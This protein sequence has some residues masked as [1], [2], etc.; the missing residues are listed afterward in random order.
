MERV[1]SPIME[2]LEK[3]EETEY[4]RNSIARGKKPGRLSQRIDYENGHKDN[5]W[6]GKG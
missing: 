4:C 5:N 2:P 1:E 6:A 3:Q